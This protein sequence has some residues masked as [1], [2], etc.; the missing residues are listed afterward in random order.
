MKPGFR[1][2]LLTG[3]ALFPAT[4]PSHPADSSP[5]SPPN[6]SLGKDDSGFYPVAPTPRNAAI[7]QAAATISKLWPRHMVLYCRQS[8]DLIKRLES[9]LDR[10]PQDLAILERLVVSLLDR[11]KENPAAISKEGSEMLLGVQTRALSGFLSNSLAANTPAPYRM[12]CARLAAS[13]MLALN[14]EVIPG[15]KPEMVT[16]NVAPPI[17]PVPAQPM[18]AGMNPDSIKDPVARAAYQ[19][20]IAKNARANALN[21]RQYCLRGTLKTL[22]FEMTAYVR[23]A[24]EKYPGLKEPGEKVLRDAGSAHRGLV[25]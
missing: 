1:T 7:A 25:P 18:M 12:H 11:E 22:E 6:P 24:T 20:A 21:S 8:E 23:A 4:A 13:F 17:M 15:F 14:K 10:H 16:A 19:E 3:L 2:W 5:A 9:G